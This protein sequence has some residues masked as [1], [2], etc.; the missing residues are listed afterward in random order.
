MSNSPAFVLNMGN[1]KLLTCRLLETNSESISMRE[2]FS[3]PNDIQ[4]V[5]AN[6]F[7]V[8]YGWEIN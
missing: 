4:N 5:A 8:R 7:D 6:E 1:I 2:T 3:Q